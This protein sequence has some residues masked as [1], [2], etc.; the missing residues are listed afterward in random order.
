MLSTKNQSKKLKALDNSQIREQWH[1]INE[2]TCNLTI[3]QKCLLPNSPAYKQKFRNTRREIF[4]HIEGV[5]YN[6]SHTRKLKEY[7]THCRKDST[8]YYCG[9]SWDDW[10]KQRFIMFNFD[11]DC[12]K[13]KDGVLIGT[14]EGAKNCV[15]FLKEHWFPDLYWEHST[16][17]VGIWG[18]VILDRKNFVCQ[19]INDIYKE[20]EGEL[21]KL[22]PLF[23]ISGIEIK[24]TCTEIKWENGKID[25][26]EPPVGSKLGI[27][28]GLPRKPGLSDTTYM[29]VGQLKNIIL[30]IRQYC[31]DRTLEAPVPNKAETERKPR[32]K[33]GGEFIKFDNASLEKW[34]S[35]AEKYLG[36]AK[37]EGKKRVKVV[38]DDMGIA[39]AILHTLSKPENMNADGTMPNRRIQTN[40]E[41]LY[42]AGEIDRQFDV[43]RWA[44]IRNH[45]SKMGFINWGSNEYCPG[46][47][48]VKGHAMEWELTET[49]MEMIELE[50][51][52]Q[53]VSV[54]YNKEE[55]ILTYLAGASFYERP[56]S[57]WLRPCLIV[58]IDYEAAYAKLQGYFPDSAAA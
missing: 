21:Q 34:N 38:L 44:A 11:I 46:S 18:W 42:A 39:L 3:G 23:D 6:C 56:P 8:A 50:V 24:G 57:M 47:P 51:M 10:R 58:D 36:V 16:G 54:S 28:G 30:S 32:L 5:A 12:H 45:L 27:F 17:E 55:Y 1:F 48:T 22:V 41:N 19:E 13:N 40:W 35:F 43:S 2:H 20:L 26:R 53:P 4:D 29:T 52:P 49:A 31:E 15:Q 25:R 7:K 37:Y 33:S 14:Q 9:T